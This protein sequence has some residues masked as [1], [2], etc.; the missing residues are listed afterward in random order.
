MSDLSQLLGGEAN[1]YDK[2]A[3][4]PDPAVNQKGHAEMGGQTNPESTGRNQS[5]PSS[6]PL[7]GTVLPESNTSGNIQH[8]NRHGYA[9]K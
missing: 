9:G 7:T 5:V 3:Q 2:G 8:G 1:Q 6:H 4:A